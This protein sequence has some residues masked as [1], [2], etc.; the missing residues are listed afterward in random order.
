ML[1]WRCHMHTGRP[2]NGAYYCQAPQA[3]SY[4]FSDPTAGGTPPA[5]GGTTTAGGAPGGRRLAQ[6]SGGCN[7][8][9]YYATCGA[10]TTRRTR[11]ELSTRRK[12]DPP[13]KPTEGL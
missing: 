2:F 10:R 5:T 4:N 6:A 3:P 7:R 9:A 8:I 11:T 1:T 13:F 12:L